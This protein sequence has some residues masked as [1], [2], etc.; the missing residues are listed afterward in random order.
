VLI[1]AGVP[2][3]SDLS[4]DLYNIL[5]ADIPS[6]DNILIATYADDTAILSDHSNNI[7]TASNCILQKSKNEH[8]IGK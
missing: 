3:G 6:T 2:Q 4:P 5:T 7:I 8:P 1:H